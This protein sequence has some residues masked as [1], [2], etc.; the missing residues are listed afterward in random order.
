MFGNSNDKN[1]EVVCLSRNGTTLYENLGV[2]GQGYLMAST[3]G[4]D[5]ARRHPSLS[6]MLLDGD[7]T[8]WWPELGVR[9]SKKQLSLNY[10]VEKS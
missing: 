1:D 10:A 5:M 2:F 6:G 7:D 9:M 3:Y 8:V 4:V